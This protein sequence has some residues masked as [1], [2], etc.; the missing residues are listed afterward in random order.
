MGKQKVSMTI[1]KEIY[2]QFK[3]YCQ[4]NGMKVSTKVELL[5]KE[6]IKDTSLKE[7]MK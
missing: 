1:D 6:T 4:K 2:N 5:I 3:K 7:Y